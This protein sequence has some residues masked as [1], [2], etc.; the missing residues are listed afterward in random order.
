VGFNLEAST[1]VHFR[2]FDESG[3]PLRDLG[4]YELKNSTPKGDRS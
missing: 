4:V 1:A 3:F 2:S